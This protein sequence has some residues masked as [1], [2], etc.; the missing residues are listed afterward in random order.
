MLASCC[1]HNSYQ[2]WNSTVHP[3]EHPWRR[4]VQVDV[5][6]FRVNKRSYSSHVCIGIL[7]PSLI[8]FYCCNIVK[9]NIVYIFY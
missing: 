7:I 8:A 5:R 2:H 3:T 4:L 9:K 6:S 1:P